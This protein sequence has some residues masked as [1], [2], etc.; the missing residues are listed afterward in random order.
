GGDDV[1]VRAVVIRHGPAVGGDAVEERLGAARQRE[2]AGED[3]REV[4]RPQV[5]RPV[6]GHV[7]RAAAGVEGGERYPRAAGQAERYN[8][9]GELWTVPIAPFSSACHAAI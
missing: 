6:C 3:R 4:E 7:R 9:G 2:G 8:G 1:L 5:L